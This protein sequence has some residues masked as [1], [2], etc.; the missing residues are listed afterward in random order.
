MGVELPRFL[1][2]SPVFDFVLRGVTKV[3]Y[4]RRLPLNHFVSK[5]RHRFCDVFRC[6]VQ[7]GTFSTCSLWCNR[8]AAV[9][10]S[11]NKITRGIKKCQIK[12]TIKEDQVQVRAVVQRAAAQRA[13]VR[14]AARN[15]AAVEARALPE[16]ANLFLIIWR[17]DIR[18]ISCLK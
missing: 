4:I 12:I 8:V 10:R 9:D 6:N 5:A 14:A 13:A 17:T 3:Y 7:Q 16:I 1:G 11:R 18:P 2:V 15:R